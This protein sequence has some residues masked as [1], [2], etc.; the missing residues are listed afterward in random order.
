MVMKPEG[1]VV[2]G[3]EAKLDDSVYLSRLLTHIAT[4]SIVLDNTLFQLAI[5]L[6]R[7]SLEPNEPEYELELAR[8]MYA[9]LMNRPEPASNVVDLAAV[10]A[11]R[12]HQPPAG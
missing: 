8:T 11:S 4:R 3:S 5:A 10:R 7:I 6:A 2:S 9:C 12:A 1:R